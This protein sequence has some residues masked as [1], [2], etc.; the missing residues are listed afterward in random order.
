MSG[1]RTIKIER[2]GPAGQDDRAPACLR[3]GRTGIAADQSVRR[4]GGQAVVPGDQVPDDRPHQAGKDHAEADDRNIDEAGADGLGD[5]R[6]KRE[7]GNEIE[8]RRPDDGL[9]WR[10]HTGRHYGGNRVGGVVKAVDE[11]ENERDE[12]QRGDR[13]EVGIHPLLQA[14][15]TT[16]PSSTLATSSQRSVAASRKSRISFHLMIAIGFCSSSNRRRSAF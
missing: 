1:A 9:A 6:T 8:H 10:Q 15:L 11:I 12:D 13:E 3:D 14:C 16:T 4:A 2:L 5:G 7:G